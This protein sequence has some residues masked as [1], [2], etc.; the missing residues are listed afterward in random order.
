MT[1]MIGGPLDGDVLSVE[2]GKAFAVAQG[3]VVYGYARAKW[4]W[5]HV[6]SERFESEEGAS[7]FVLCGTCW[8]ELELA[9]MV[10]D[11]EWLVKLWRLVPQEG[12]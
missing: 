4:A 11:A 7:E 6:W 8:T 12:R 1:P 3:N 2:G 5:W 9:L 10:R